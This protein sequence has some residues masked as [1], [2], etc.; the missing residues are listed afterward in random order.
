MNEATDNTTAKRRLRRAVLARRTTAAARLP[1][2]GSALAETFLDA[3]AVP[4]GAS[5]AG[6][7]PIRDEIDPHPLMRRLH[8]AAHAC[9]L[10]VIGGP[11][12][13]LRF[14]TWKPGM[15]LEPGGFGTSVPPAD[16]AEVV[17]G[18]VLTP[19]LAFDE[20]GHRLGYGGG[21]YDR[22]L[23]ALRARG[24]AV[25]AVGL[26]YEA[27]RIATV[28]NTPGDARLDWVVTEGRAR[29]TA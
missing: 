13:A 18:V 25:L 1:D 22:T 8:Q 3:I 6:Y 23:T 27:Q 14:R 11:A 7:W 24:G 9:A 26:A 10:C 20:R 19:L 2:A 5:V 16:A 29:R 21:Y 12:A 4:P 17:P 28:P 15:V